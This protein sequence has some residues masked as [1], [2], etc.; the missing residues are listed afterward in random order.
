M[1][2]IITKKQFNDQKY[3]AISAIKKAVRNIPE[4]HSMSK[5]SARLSVREYVESDLDLQKEF[6]D[7]ENIVKGIER[8]DVVLKD[9]GPEIGKHLKK[10]LKYTGGGP[11]ETFDP[12]LVEFLNG[13][14]ALLRKQGDVNVTTKHQAQLHY[15]L[16]ITEILLK[17]IVDVE[18][19]IESSK[20]LESTVQG[21]NSVLDHILSD[22]VF[23][24]MIKNSIKNE[25]KMNSVQKPAVT[26][27]RKSST[28]SYETL[29]MV[30]LSRQQFE[31]RRRA[32][33]QERLQE[34]QKRL[35]TLESEDYVG[36]NNSRSKTATVSTS[37]TIE[38]PVLNRD[39][40]TRIIDQRRDRNNPHKMINLS[41]L[42]DSYQTDGNGKIIVT[43]FY[44]WRVLRGFDFSHTNIAQIFDFR[45]FHV[46]DCNFEGCDFSNV[47]DQT[48]LKSVVF[49]GCNL[50]RAN[51]S[52]SVAEIV[53]EDNTRF[54]QVNLTDADVAFYDDVTVDHRDTNYGSAR[55][56]GWSSGIKPR[57]SNINMVGA[58]VY[59]EP[60][61]YG[62]SVTEVTEQ[63]SKDD[64]AARFGD[65]PSYITANVFGDQNRFKIVKVVPCS[66]KSVEWVHQTFFVNEPMDPGVVGNF[67][68]EARETMRAHLDESYKA[69]NITF[70]NASNDVK[71]TFT[72]EVCKMD[73]DWFC[74]LGLAS[75]VGALGNRGGIVMTSDVEQEGK[76]DTKEWGWVVNHEMGHLT[77][78]FHPFNVGIGINDCS[79]LVSQMCYRYANYF[80][81]PIEMN[82]RQIY[83]LDRSPSNLGT[84]DYKAFGL[85]LGVDLDLESGN[86]VTVIRTGETR[87][88]RGNDGFENTLIAN[89]AEWQS[90]N[91]TA[92]LRDAS[93]VVKNINFAT[94]PGIEG[95][96][97]V[98]ADQNGNV[99]SVTLMFGGKIKIDIPG[100]NHQSQ[101]AENTAV[102]EFISRTV[103]DSI[104]KSLSSNVFRNVTDSQSL[105]VNCPEFNAP[106]VAVVSPNVENIRNIFSDICREVYAL[107]I[108]EEN[109]QSLISNISQGIGN[110][111]AQ[112]LSEDRKLTGEELSDF[113]NRTISN[114]DISIDADE[115]RTIFTPIV[116]ATGFFND[117]IADCRSQQ[118]GQDGLNIDQKI[119]IGVGVGGFCA[120]LASIAAYCYRSRN[121]SAER[122]DIEMGR[123]E[124]TAVGNPM[125][126][127][128]SSEVES[129]FGESVQGQLSGN[130]T[131]SIT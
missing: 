66:D 34:E 90:K 81:P 89:E 37:Q 35:R 111:V 129:V 54:T 49:E 51:F 112:S 2:V 70:V 68:D 83:R 91:L 26:G 52:N 24:K 130:T 42:K 46:S 109:R 40:L 33:I 13:Q 71:E 115:V 120:I 44:S 31:Q 127:N 105:S 102:N 128:P 75:H 94:P 62:S 113:V 10:Q 41:D 73:A 64:V 77:G 21:H 69:F 53:L 7:Y 121:N 63:I 29:D 106:C 122:D 84:Q 1:A 55:R 45:G 93:E 92:F 14:R 22:D 104:K 8:G 65:Y 59:C 119:G 32:V 80:F 56:I 60:D 86:M 96:L 17:I 110:M 82:G 116:A 98:V 103:S 3:K 43:D 6:E 76:F 15:F 61:V 95:S 48:P 19:F 85:L 50:H 27:E 4:I 18:G 74:C 123:R 23:D 114:S 107:D 125:S 108:G 67:T 5:E 88:V 99:D 124:P 57:G 28:R 126:R 16:K 117:M 72:V 78:G 39:E 87:V 101:T 100:Y 36:E 131:P 30:E 79:Q 97:V 118:G 58:R 20:A 38:K 25:Q 47:G 9:S 11:Q 12:N